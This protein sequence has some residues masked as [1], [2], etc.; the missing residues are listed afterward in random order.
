MIGFVQYSWLRIANILFWIPLT[1]LKICCFRV[2][3][4]NLKT[5]KHLASSSQIS[6]FNE[7]EATITNLLQKKGVWSSCTLN[8]TVPVE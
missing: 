7:L 5:N 8:K 6:D 1:S 3:F 2:G 4:Y